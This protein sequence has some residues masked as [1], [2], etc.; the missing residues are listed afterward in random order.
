MNEPKNQLTYKEETD[1]VLVSIKKNCVT[2]IK[3]THREPQETLEPKL[4]KPIQTIAFKPSISIEKS[5][6]LGLTSLEV[7][8]S[9]FL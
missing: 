1:D 8:N 2:L 5:W 3:K 7:N 9:I 4:T 6:M